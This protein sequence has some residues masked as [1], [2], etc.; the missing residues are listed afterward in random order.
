MPPDGWLHSLPRFVFFTGKGGVGKTS[1]ACAAAVHLADAG[2][3]VLLVSTDP[4]SN[5]GQVF[6]LTIGDAITAI[7]DVPGLEALEIDP[8]QAADAYRE[9][10]ISP[11]RGLL[12]EREIASITEQL[13]GSCTTEIAS[14]NEFTGFLAD[15][16][17]TARYDH[18]IFDT[19]PTGHTIRLLQL[20]GDWTSFLDEGKGDASCLGPM[21]GLDR[22]RG[23][24]AVAL[25]RLSDPSVTRM[26]LVARAQRSALREAARTATDLADLGITDQWL[27]VNGVMPADAAGTQTSGAHAD[28]AHAD[29]AQASGP[30]ADSAHADGVQAGGAQAGGAQAGG[31]QAAGTQPNSAHAASPTDPLVAAIRARE[32]AALAMLPEALSRLPLAQVPLCAHTMVGA[33]AL[34]ELLTP[35]NAK[36]SHAAGQLRGASNGQPTGHAELDPTIPFGLGGLVDELAEAGAG[37]VMC[38]GKGGVGKT[39]VAAA[40]AVALA[41]RGLDIHLTTTDP[42]AH[43]N[44]TL[45]GEVPHLTVSRIDPHA[46]TTAYRERVMATKGAALHE[47]GRARLAEDLE[48]PCTEEVAV[49]QQFSRLVHESRRHLVIMDTAPTGH[50]LL[51]MD[52]TGS[53]HRDVVRTM[54]E[55]VSYTTPLMRLQ[56]P[57]Q[58]R[59]VIVTL[60]DTTPVLEAEGLVADLRRASIEPWAWV[61]N[62]SLAAA[63]PSSPLLAQRATAELPHIERVC[64]Q[65][66]GN[67]VAIIPLLAKDPVGVVA[68]REL[69]HFA[70]PVA[71]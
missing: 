14:F 61:I 49:F 55:G 8:E 41:D 56:D 30:Q 31:A 28:G 45:A 60:P 68:L 18:V 69:S 27:V 34:R 16:A 23:M 53:Y 48:S 5:V 33:Q 24:Y 71:I 64:R 13:S 58:T 22:T 38:M 51:L 4:A 1:L 19:A 63:Q 37:L 20:P 21:A 50:T 57:E 47:A 29:G 54:G 42:A 52:A 59:V 40:L 12:P 62:S 7:P 44:D 32:Q 9:R 26:V 66:P 17:L 46:A 10:I 35:S 25:Q 15:D 6:G 11:V 39:T 70:I 3:R 65:A 2:K 36:A 67:R 43:L